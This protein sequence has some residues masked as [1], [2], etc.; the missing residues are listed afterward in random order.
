MVGSIEQLANLQQTVIANP[1]LVDG[2]LS[3][4]TDAL[5]DA[6]V[7]LVKRIEGALEP[8]ATAIRHWYKSYAKPCPPD[9]EGESN[10]AADS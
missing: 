2:E 8:Q 6:T 3:L 4:A 7:A 9:P 10:D 1:D 5:R